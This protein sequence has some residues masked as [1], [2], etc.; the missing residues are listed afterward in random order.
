MKKLLLIAV[1]ASGIAHAELPNCTRASVWAA[2]ARTGSTLCETPG[3][4]TWCQ[5]RIDAIRAC[6]SDAQALEAISL[7]EAAMQRAVVIDK[8]ER[9]QEAAWA[10]EAKRRAALPGVRIGMTPNDVINNTSW[11]K[12]KSVNRTI[13]AYGRSEQWVYGSSNYLYFVNGTLTTIQN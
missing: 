7:Y 10:K 11:G 5:E 9:A 1:M 4:A 8:K 13:T 2:M 12:P 3:D 6:H